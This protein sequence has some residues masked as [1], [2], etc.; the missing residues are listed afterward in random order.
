MTLDKMLNLAEQRKALE[1][2]AHDLEGPHTTL[3]DASAFTTLITAL[4]AC[5]GSHPLLRAECFRVMILATKASSLPT[6]GSPEAWVSPR[7]DA[8]FAVC[9]SCAA[10][11]G[12]EEG[13]SELLQSAEEALL[14][15]KSAGRHLLPVLFGKLVSSLC[16]YRRTHEDAGLCTRVLALSLACSQPPSATSSEAWVGDR[17]DTLRALADSSLALLES[18]SREHVPLFSTVAGALSLLVGRLDESENESADDGGFQSAALRPHSA[19]APLV[20]RASFQCRRLIGLLPLS[21][22]PLLI[23]FYASLCDSPLALFSP[24]LA[25]DMFLLADTHPGTNVGRLLLRFVRHGVVRGQVLDA[26]FANVV[27]PGVLA[28]LRREPTCSAVVHYGTDVLHLLTARHTPTSVSLWRPQLGAPDTLLLFDTLAAVSERRVLSECFLDM[29]DHPVPRH[30]LR[31]QVCAD[32]PAS[33]LRLR[34]ERIRMLSNTI[35]SIFEG[36]QLAEELPAAT[37]AAVDCLERTVESFAAGHSEVP[38]YVAA[39]VNILSCLTALLMEEK[40]DRVL[41]L[42]ALRSS[43]TGYRASFPA[44]DSTAINAVLN[45]VSLAASSKDAQCCTFALPLLFTE[46]IAAADNLSLRSI[47]AP[48]LWQHVVRLFEAVPAEASI[49]TLLPDETV[50]AN[51]F[52]LYPPSKL[53]A[54]KHSE[55]YTGWQLSLVEVLKR[56]GSG[57]TPFLWR[58]A[59]RCSVEHLVALRASPKKQ[60]FLSLIGRTFDQ[61]LLSDVESASLKENVRLSD[62]T[63]ALKISVPSPRPGSLSLVGDRLNYRTALCLSRAAAVLGADDAGSRRSGLLQSD[64]MDTLVVGFDSLVR[65]YSWKEML[66]KDLAADMGDVCR[67]LASACDVISSLATA[68]IENGILALS[69]TPSLTSALLDASRA[70][71]EWSLPA[72]ALGSRVASVDDCAM[73]LSAVAGVFVSLIGPDLFLVSPTD[74][75]VYKPLRDAKVHT[76]LAGILERHPDIAT[77]SKELRTRVSAVQL[78]LDASRKSKNELTE[79]EAQEAR[80]LQ[81]AKSAAADKMMAELLAEESAKPAK[82]KKGKA[83]Q[84]EQPAAKKG[85]KKKKGPAAKRA[86]VSDA[87]EEEEAEAEAV[88]E[89]EASVDAAPDAAAES[90][91]QAPFEPE[92]AAENVLPPEVSASPAAAAEAEEAGWVE[93]LAKAKQRHGRGDGRGVAALTQAPTPAGREVEGVPPPLSLAAAPNPP[94][95][96][97]AEAAP[98]KKS[99]RGGR[100]GGGKEELPPLLPDEGA[101]AASE[102]ASAERLLRGAAPATPAAEEEKLPLPPHFPLSAALEG[103]RQGQGGRQGRG[104]KVVSEPRASQSQNPPPLTPPLRQTSNLKEDSYTAMPFIPSSSDSAPPTPPPLPAVNESSLVPQGVAAFPPLPGSR[105]A[106]W[107]PSLPSAPTS[108]R[109][110]LSDE[111]RPLPPAPP[112]SLGPVPVPFPPWQPE[113]QPLPVARPWA[114]HPAGDSDAA[115]AQKPPRPYKPPSSTPAPGIWAQLGASTLAGGGAGAPWGASAAPAA[116]AQLGAGLSNAQGEY[117]CFLNSVVQ[118]LYRLRCFREYLLSRDIK[119][120]TDEAPRITASKRLLEAL[121]GLC[122]ALRNGGQLRRS[123]EASSG[124]VA[125]NALRSALADMQGSGGEGGQLNEMADASEVLAAFYGAFEVVTRA[126][127]PTLV[128]DSSTIARMFSIGVSERVVCD[129]RG[130]SFISHAFS[131]SQNFH[132]VAAPALREVVPD[133]ING[134]SPFESRLARLLEMDQKGCDKDLKPPGCGRKLPVEHT[135]KRLPVVFTLSLT[136][137]TATAPEKE[138]METMRALD[139]KLRPARI[140]RGREAGFCRSVWAWVSS[141]GEGGGQIVADAQEAKDASYSLRAMVCY[142]GAHYATFARTGDDGG[143][144][145]ARFDDANVSEVGDWAA[146]CSSCA[147]GHLQPT[148]LFFELDNSRF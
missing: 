92:V 143:G 136:W 109:P 48:V 81:E 18:D 59:F 97:G 8:L 46:A 147:R 86:V 71:V 40:R 17:R 10:S 141:D 137:D 42:R 76:V 117:N 102:S 31:V 55:L 24:E 19:D 96:D 128:P 130:G 11:L 9:A 134:I 78:T 16:D 82:G 45:F 72:K 142:Y 77:A 99:K 20:Q 1:S 26:A 5:A 75:N 103:A 27:G 112:A 116:P 44:Y 120:G 135:A 32:S 125:P 101:A 53:D 51:A 4:T 66:T 68:N 25:S 57:L 113:P 22:A 145:W 114:T 123:E 15:L 23:S 146:L 93:P 28:A 111:G 144:P 70:C 41:L 107:Q 115:I 80:E 64:V 74:A 124:A 29:G 139:D 129:C 126:H 30:G 52:L 119:F 79:K 12:G 38:E 122:G 131:Y 54:E 61:L 110:A 90:E 84:T 43:W 36:F 98:R 14:L 73:L 39:A 13:N 62:L 63:K 7:A 138:V 37:S 49:S 6:A 94:G 34:C 95:G 118:S 121:K 127:N 58:T 104:S 91:P 148:V 106:S 2:L 89:V 50:L 133:Y 83:A 140:F 56:L 108:P 47:G 69:G 21:D 3:S 88:V 60:H 105:N 87:E 85:G 132:L 35:I 33:L 67:L 100:G 65:N